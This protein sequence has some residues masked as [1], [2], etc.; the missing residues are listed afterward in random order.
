VRSFGH[1]ALPAATPAWQQLLPGHKAPPTFHQLRHGQN[2]RAACEMRA[3]RYWLSV[4]KPRHL[5]CVL[6]AMFFTAFFAKAD[7]IAIGSSLPAI[8]GTTETGASLDLT[9]LNKGYTLVYFYPRA[10]TRGCTAQGCSLRDAYDVL[11][12]RNVTVIGVSTDTVEKQKD[13]KD[14]QHFPF[15]LIADPD[16]K[17]I[18]A[19]GV[20]TQSK[21]IIGEYASR[22]AFL[23]KD[24]K[25]VWR[26]LKAATKDQAEDVLKELD[27]LGG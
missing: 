7:P 22:Q 12:K 15:T 4:M 16:K 19:F 20:P 25:L 10:G 2:R 9:T 8:T 18:T 13:F 23:F 11:Q 1:R 3:A 17:V 5:A 6:L 24:G 21:P 26:D 27:L 14:Q